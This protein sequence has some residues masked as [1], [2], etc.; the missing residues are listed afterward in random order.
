M[1]LLLLLDSTGHEISSSCC[2]FHPGENRSGSGGW[3]WQ[4]MGAPSFPS[5]PQ[6]GWRPA[7]KL[8]FLLTLPFWR[9]GTGETNPLN[10][11]LI[12]R[13]I[14]DAVRSAAAPLMSYKEKIR[15]SPGNF[16]SSAD[17]PLFSFHPSTV[18]L[19]SRFKLSNSLQ[20]TH[21]AR[22][23][24]SGLPFFYILDQEHRS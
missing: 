19:R 16:L 9:D 17:S 6:S 20:H 5:L 23:N 4:A 10:L 1:L 14:K 13:A 15:F 21:A 24:T 11:D 8:C 3:N 7:D 18:F 22:D 12:N 2:V